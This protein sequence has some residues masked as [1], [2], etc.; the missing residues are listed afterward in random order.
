MARDICTLDGV[1]ADRRELSSKS[2]IYLDGGRCNL[3]TRDHVTVY[4]C[5]TSSLH[6]VYFTSRARFDFGSYSKGF[7]WR[8][9]CYLRCA[10]QLGVGW[11][12]GDS[13]VSVGL[14]RRDEN[15]RFAGQCTRV[16]S[17]FIAVPVAVVA[18][19]N[20]SFRLMSILRPQDC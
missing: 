17:I 18:V 6:H 8:L 3:A 12:A 15:V 1:R 19:V 10:W 16:L 5:V 20:P 7:V 9:R 14:G 13:F 2:R 4:P 11:R